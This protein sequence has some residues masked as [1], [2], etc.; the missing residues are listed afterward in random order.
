MRASSVVRDLRTPRLRM[1][2]FQSP[3]SVIRLLHFLDV[4][5]RLVVLARYQRA[6]AVR[7]R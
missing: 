6:M 3:P 5:D 7:T 4:N 2:G 1:R